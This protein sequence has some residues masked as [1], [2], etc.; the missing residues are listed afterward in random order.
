M[1]ESIASYNQ[2]S[3]RQP[4]ELGETSQAMASR[5]VHCANPLTIGLGFENIDACSCQGPCTCPST[6]SENFLVD[7]LPA[8]RDAI[9]LQLL[10]NV[11]AISVRIAKLEQ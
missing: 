2:L 11:A 10:R 3:L 7:S 4:S 5:D 1:P 8:G 9:I 6:I